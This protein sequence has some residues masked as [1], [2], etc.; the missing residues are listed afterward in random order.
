MIVLRVYPSLRVSSLA[1]WYMAV[2]TPAYLGH[3]AAICLLYPLH[4]TSPIVPRPTQVP[5]G[6]QRSS[7][8]TS[9]PPLRVLNPLRSNQLLAC[10]KFLSRHF[11]GPRSFQHGIMVFRAGCLQLFSKWLC[12]EP[13][14]ALLVSLP[15]LGDVALCPMEQLLS[16]GSVSNLSPPSPSPF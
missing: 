14:T 15:L 1:S 16:G 13:G 4:L 12:R 6:S 2:R 9:T 5:H 7:E 11:P 3:G 10:I 8:D